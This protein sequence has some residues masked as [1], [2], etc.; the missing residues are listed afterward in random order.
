ME[1]LRRA[2][3]GS[4]GGTNAA[5]KD[6]DKSEAKFRKAQ[7]EYKALVDKYCSVRDD[8]ERK[9]TLSS[10]R[11]QVENLSLLETRFSSLKFQSIIFLG[12]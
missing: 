9:M 6:L 4:V 11:F 5:A 10:K 12:G 7:E 2:A 1:R 8:F 3:D